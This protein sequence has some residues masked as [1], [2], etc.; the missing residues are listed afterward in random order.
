M[1]GKMIAEK[2]KEKGLTQD[3][4]GAMLGISGKA[5]S[6]W[7]RGLSQ[8]DAS[9]IGKLT[10]LLGLP[11]EQTADE[12]DTRLTFLSTVKREVS[13]ILSVGVM[14]AACVCYLMGTISTDSTIVA[15]GFAA[16][17]FCF[18]TMIREK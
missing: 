10:E 9:H 13:R 14:L 5:V 6:K 1:D 12:A 2:R 16:V 11:V 4:L 17:V 18:D 15:F 7:E 3:A 8:P